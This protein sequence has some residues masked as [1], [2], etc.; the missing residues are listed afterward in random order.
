MNYQRLNNLTG[1]AVFA[2]ALIVYLATVAPTASFWDCGE[3]IAC[4]NELEVT[5]P[6]GAPFYLLLG[7]IFALLA[8]SV[9]SIA[10]MVNLLSVFASAFTALF[11]CWITTMLVEKVL[12]RKAWSE[13][14]KHITIM[15]SGVIAG[16]SCAFADSIWFNAVEAEVYALSTFFTAIVFWLMLKWER[17]AD[18]PDHA[19][20][21]ILIAYLMGLSTGVHLLNLLT[22]PALALI[23]YY[24][25]FSFSW[26]GLLA[27]LGISFAAL[28][29]I[30]YG[31][32]QSTFDMAWN[33]ERFFTGTVARDGAEIGG[34]G[35]SMGTGAGLFLGLIVVVLVGLL[36]YSQMAR[37]AVLNTVLLCY[38][39]IILGFSSYALIFIRSQ[40]NPPIDMNNPENLLTFLSYMKREQY[41]DRPLVKGPLYNGQISFSEEG[42]AIFDSV[43][44]KYM[45]VEGEERY[46]ED[47]VVRKYTYDNEVWFPRMHAASRYNARP[48]GYRYFVSNKGA[49]PDDPTDDQPTRGEDFRFFL[50]YQ[51]KHMYLRYFMWNFVG[52]EGDEQ[53]DR[54]ESGFEIGDESRYVRGKEEN[55][56]KNHY[57]YIP[58]FLGLIGLVWHSLH[59]RNDATVIAL[60]F[61]F[62]GLAIIIYLNQYPAQPRERDYSFVGSFQAFSIWIGMGVAFMVELARNR[63][64]ELTP[65]I[66]IGLA[67]LGPFFMLVNN[68][69]DH[70]R[71]GRWVDVEFAKNLL[72]TCDPEA[73]LFTGGDNDTFP[74]WYVQEVEGYRT[75]VR[76]VNLE[77]L[78]SD[79]YIDQVRAERNQQVGIPL[80]LKRE[81]YQGDQGQLLM[82]FPSQQIPFPVNVAALTER[83]VFNETEA[84]A[85]V[86]TMVWD[87]QAKGSAR[88][89][90]ILRK[91]LVLLNMLQQISQ[92]DWQRPI[93][94]TGSM[95]PENYLNL[96]DFLRFEGLAY[97]LIPLKK[98]ELT[99]NDRFYMGTIRPDILRKNLVDTYRYAGLN[100]PDVYLDEHI[101]NLILANYRNAFLRLM[102]AYE[103][104]HR[105]AQIRIAAVDSLL[106]GQNPNR[107][108]EL[109]EEKSQLNIHLN[110]LRDTVKQVYAYGQ[111]VMPTSVNPQP[112]LILL[113]Q[114]A[115]ILGFVGLTDEALA[116]YDQLGPLSIQALKDDIALQRKIDQTHPGLQVCIFS[117]QAYLNYGKKIKARELADYL[118]VLTG[119]PVGE[120][121]IEE[122]EKSQTP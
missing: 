57:F 82:G 104:Q 44:T 2:V 41:G 32:I 73:I 25:K 29:S 119:S 42:R 45:V 30:Q 6:P 120:L 62:T 106:E 34:M 113:Y 48:Y 43:R 63:L 7:R 89:P 21:I 26:T 36:V 117:I 96:T 88:N 100:D 95:S 31:I 71:K 27:T 37:K 83:G 9:E 65:W 61:F 85:A 114:Q 87:F 8:P 105:S 58:L 122:Y 93:Y 46:V 11:T 68:W 92:A 47:M 66:A 116:A 90:Y 17:R 49:D 64:R 51:I 33:F 60:L 35:W 108:P 1:W 40:A 75:D 118:K 20:Y 99:L 4:A 53:D 5:H 91:D 55:K 79:W 102:G 38:L 56:G 39:M 13:E 69:D 19:R 81:D 103:A 70:T 112:N 59:Q 77:L 16:L 115:E 22:I 14:S 23:F 98:S 86:D 97:R 18:R 74:L 84:Q 121:I 52:R 109:I 24:R 54:W 28:A 72:D 101:R 3:F 110:A 76:V 10:F 12:S 78:I 50:E 15:G 67:S 94:F 80:S 107:Y 111:T